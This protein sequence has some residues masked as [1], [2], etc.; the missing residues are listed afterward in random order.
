MIFLKKYIKTSYLL[1]K[2]DFYFY[3]SILKMFGRSD[4]SFSKSKKKSQIN[5][6]LIDM[7]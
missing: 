4:D 5:D 1:I 2:S 3:K 6:A 7:S